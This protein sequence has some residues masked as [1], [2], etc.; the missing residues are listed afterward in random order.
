MR[1]DEVTGC[2]LS[3][4]LGWEGECKLSGVLVRG[5]EDKVVRGAG[6]GGEDAVVMGA[7]WGG[8]WV[9]VLAVREVCLLSGVLGGMQLSGVLVWGCKL[10]VALGS[11]LV[12]RACRRGT[13]CH[14]CW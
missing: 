6:R 5:G 11:V 2:Q 4:V 3:G 12:D 14:S 8:R 13:S 7:V 1:E 10:S 9:Q